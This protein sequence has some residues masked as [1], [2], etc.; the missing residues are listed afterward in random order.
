MSTRMVDV[1]PTRLQRAV[2]VV[3]SVVVILAS[4]YLIFGLNPIDVC[5]WPGFIL[6]GLKVFQWIMLKRYCCSNCYATVSRDEQRC[7]NCGANLTDANVAR[8][9]S[10]EKREKPILIGI[11]ILV[12]IPAMAVF[13]IFPSIL[14]A[15]GSFG[16]MATGA[17]SDRYGAAY[18]AGAGIGYICALITKRVLID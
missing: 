16:A 5:G 11:T 6:L 15:T 14:A 4:L 1:S 10:K 2:I 8:V 9:E 7:Y 17:E 13:M 3:S 12:G 18:I